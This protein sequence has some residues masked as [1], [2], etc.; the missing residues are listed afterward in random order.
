MSRRFRS[1]AGL[2]L[3]HRD[4]EPDAGEGTAAGLSAAA[5]VEPRGLS[6]PVSGHDLAQVAQADVDGLHGRV[7]VALV[8]DHVPLHP[9]DTLAGL[10]ELR[11]RRFIL[12]DGRLEPGVRIRFRH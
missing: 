12:A 4:G 1:G 8:F 10:Q 7:L 6:L 5:Q 3:A 11:P 9:T 2:S